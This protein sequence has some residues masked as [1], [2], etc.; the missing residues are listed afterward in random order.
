MFDNLETAL[1]QALDFFAIFCFFFYKTLFA[2]KKPNNPIINPKK[3]M[4]SVNKKSIK[5]ETKKRFIY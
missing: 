3:T 2:N 5:I 1:I 4:I